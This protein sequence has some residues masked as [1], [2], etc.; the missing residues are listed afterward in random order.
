VCQEQATSPTNITT[1]TN[2]A[3][4]RR[5]ADADAATPRNDMYDPAC[6]TLAPVPRT[7]THVTVQ[8]FQL[9]VQTIMGVLWSVV[10]T[11]WLSLETDQPLERGCRCRVRRV[12]SVLASWTDCQSRLRN[13]WST[14][15]IAIC[16]FN[17][18]APLAYRRPA[19]TTTANVACTSEVPARPRIPLAF[20]VFCDRRRNIRVTLFQRPGL[21]TQAV[22]V[23]LAT[24]QR[25]AVSVSP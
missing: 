12:S 17:Q 23:H 11:C 8:G 9:L 21:C 3:R 6:A 25:T 10:P 18:S 1:G 15:G 13:G 14:V 16:S 20:V 5:H 4:R 2:L 19:P 7:Q 24:V 22:A